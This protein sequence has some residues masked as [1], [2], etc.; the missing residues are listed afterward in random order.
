[1]AH[2]SLS[3]D[4]LQLLRGHA[5][6]DGVSGWKGCTLWMPPNNSEFTAG[7]PRYDQ[8]VVVT[9]YGGA[10]RNAIE[11]PSVQIRVRG[12]AYDWAG[13][14]RKILDILDLLYPN[15]LPLGPFTVNGRTYAWIRARQSRPMFL[16]VDQQN[17]RPEFAQN[18]DVA[19]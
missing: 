18:Y 9:G 16:G 5:L 10:R 12:T 17:W 6:V 4:V 2:P 15:D 19:I 11:Q 3:D 1:M 8:V 14:E 7:D 13:T